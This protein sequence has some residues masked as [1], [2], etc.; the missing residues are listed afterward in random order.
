MV[1]IGADSGFV[2]GVENRKRSIPVF[3]TL[4]VLADAWAGEK[5]F[6]SSTVAKQW[7]HKRMVTTLHNKH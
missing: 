5:A 7:D 2:F 3:M 1:S 4:H 6:L